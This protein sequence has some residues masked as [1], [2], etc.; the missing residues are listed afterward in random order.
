M[1]VVAMQQY[2]DC[3]TALEMTQGVA[4]VDVI[5]D[6]PQLDRPS[7]EVLVGPGYERVP[8]RVLNVITDH[9]FGTRPDLSGS[10]GQPRH[11]LVVVT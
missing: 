10:V 9:D 7:I 1:P 11:F 2:R 5:D 3:A 4:A 6:P 8:R